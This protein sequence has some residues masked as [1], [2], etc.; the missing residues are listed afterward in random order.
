[1][2]QDEHALWKPRLEMLEEVVAHQP[3]LLIEDSEQCHTVTRFS[4]ERVGYVRP[5]ITI[6]ATT[7]V[8]ECWRELDGKVEALSGY[9]SDTCTPPI[10]WDS[11]GSTIQERLTRLAPKA[12]QYLEADDG[13]S[14]RFIFQAWIWRILDEKLFSNK[15]GPWAGEHWAAYSQLRSLGARK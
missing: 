5:Y 9:L 14:P 10:S 6:P 15:E 11:L 7:R 1:M 13:F 2:L 4:T 12:K 8:Y 3:Q